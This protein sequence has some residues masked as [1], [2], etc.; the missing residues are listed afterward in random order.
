MRPARTIQAMC[1]LMLFFSCKD[2]LFQKY[3][4]R[5]YEKNELK[6]NV[7]TRDNF[8]ETVSAAAA[9]ADIYLADNPQGE[10]YLYK[11]KAG[12]DGVF[13]LP[14][15][16]RERSGLYIVGRM[17]S[18]SGIVYEASSG[19]DDM[20]VDQEGNRILA[21][22]PHYRSGIIKTVVTGDKSPGEPV[23][24]AAVFLFTNLDLAA[25]VKDSV[26]TGFVQRI[27]TNEK[28]IA[29][30][31]NL[32]S[33]TYYVSAR[34]KNILTNQV[35]INVDENMTRADKEAIT[36]QVLKLQKTEAKSRIIVSIRDTA[37]NEPL[38]SLKLY[39][40][41]SRLQAES[42]RDSTGAKGFI[43][44]VVTTYT[45]EAL[46]QNLNA[47]KYY[48][49]VTGDVPVDRRLIYIEEIPVIVENNQVEAYRRELQI[50]VARHAF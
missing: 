1:I 37:T 13:R 27:T 46:F 8:M 11:V 2:K 15:Q 35:A 50:N 38:S 32:K 49:G 17:T 23:N 16:P 44:T 24:G 3:D 39:L 18:S 33:G 26:P 19:I 5:L 41:T 40:F 9:E 28:G 42:L 45:G 4:V 10:P 31:H 12:K 43:G 48:I 30:F 47:G 20:E 29:F 6:G 36:A 34:Q 14:F 25:S 22:R 21:L 7:L